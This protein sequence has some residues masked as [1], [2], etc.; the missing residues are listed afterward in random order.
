MDTSSFIT[1]L[2]NSALL[3]ALGVI[4]DALS[5]ESI[6]N[7]MLRD[8]LSGLFVGMLG[9]AVMNTPWEMAPGIIFDTRWVLI[10]LCGLFFGLVPT[11][12]AAVIMVSLRL[13]IGGTGAF[14][15][16]LVIVIPACTGYLFAYIL[17]Q[18]NLSLDWF[19]LYAFGMLIQISVLSCMLLMPEHLRYKII[20]AL[21][22]PLILIF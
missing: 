12:I 15:G 18:K 9:L 17:K 8:L 14:V 3:I 4:Y 16:S 7:K 2:Y 22:L 1:L 19:K 21:I 11:L 20:D 6:K 5:L 13:H 10:S